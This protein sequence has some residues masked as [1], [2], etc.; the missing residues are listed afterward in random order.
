MTVAAGTGS[1]L[2]DINLGVSMPLQNSPDM[3]K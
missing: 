2:G 1:T 3:P